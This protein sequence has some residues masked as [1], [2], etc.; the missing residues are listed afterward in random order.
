MP[1]ILDNKNPSLPPVF[2]PLR[3]FEKRGGERASQV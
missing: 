2:R 1:V 3:S